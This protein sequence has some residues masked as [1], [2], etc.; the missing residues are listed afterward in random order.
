MFKALKRKRI[1]LP[2]RVCQVTWRSGRATKIVKLRWWSSYTR[3]KIGVN[4][5]I[6]EASLA[7][8]FLEK[9][10]SSPLKS[11]VAKWL[12]QRW[13]I[14]N[15]VF[16]LAAALQTKLS[17]YYKFHRNRG[18]TPMM[19]THVLCVLRETYCR[20]PRKKLCR[21]CKS[22]DGHLLMTVK[23]LYSFIDNCVGVAGVV[24]VSRGPWPP[25]VLAYLVILCLEKQHPTQKYGCSP[26]IKLS[27]REKFWAGY[28]TGRS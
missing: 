2:T 3:K 21:S 1:L 27:T 16:V 20:D 18:N 8:A 6:T 7:P 25:K 23:S 15:A 5:F 24:D 4:A 28:A 26:K 9:C 12:N 19:T 17:F 22:F 10:M 11:D 14:P 13:I